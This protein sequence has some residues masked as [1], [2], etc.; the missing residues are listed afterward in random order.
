MFTEQEN[1]TI[2]GG[3]NGVASSVQETATQPEPLAVVPEWAIEIAG[4]LNLH[5]DNLALIFDGL[6]AV[7]DQ[8]TAV[9]DQLTFVLAS[10]RV[11]IAP[12]VLVSN[13]VNREAK[14]KVA[15]KK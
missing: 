4:T 15:A 6:K 8:L 10:L 9:N 5:T 12:P 1:G 7:N 2:N 11:L 14:E 3:Q 13:A